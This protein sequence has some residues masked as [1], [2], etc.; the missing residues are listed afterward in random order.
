MKLIEITNI[1]IVDTSER[2]FFDL[3]VE[4]DT[5]YTVTCNNIAVHNSH[6]KTRTMTG[7]GFPQ[8]SIVSE[9]SNYFN[10]VSDGGCKTVADIA[11]A[12]VVGAEMVMVGSMLAGHKENS[13]ID[14]SIKW[15]NDWDIPNNDIKVPMRGMSSK[16]AMIDHY[17]EMAS[18]RASEG[19]ETMISYRG[20]I[21]NTIEEILGG[22]RSTC[23][24]VNA[25]NINELSGKKLVKIT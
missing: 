24:Y 20:T 7:V 5:S 4:D 11:K 18:Y 2:E 1:E 13:D 12:F 17:G 8:M 16:S 6:C 21:K 22:L 23:T 9:L 3:S 25:S 15:V 10:V 19:H 14:T